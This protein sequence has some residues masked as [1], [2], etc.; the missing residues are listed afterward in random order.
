V[1][2]Q[3]SS[4]L[5]QFQNVPV[6]ESYD[7]QYFSPLFGIEDK[8]YWFRA[9]NQAIVALTRQVVSDL[10]PGYRVLEVGCGTGNVLRVLTHIC[11]R[12]TVIGMDLFGEGLAYARQR[13]DCALIQGDINTPPFAAC[14]DLI[15]LFDVLE[16]LPDDVQV[17][18][19]LGGLLRQGGKLLLTVPAHMSLWSY[20]DVAAH[21]CR[22]YAPGELRETMYR[23]G[24]RVEYLTQYMGSIFPF[25][26]LGR[27]VAALTN[28][29]LMGKA[30]RT[31]DLATN[32]LR[33]I[34]VLNDLLAWLLIQEIR[35]LERRRQLPFGTSLIA[36][37]H[38]E[39]RAA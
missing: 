20:F 16:H 25:V 18:R 5:T 33:I 7:P 6:P 3:E 19:N 23:A 21:H 34:P 31:Y 12:G 38:K 11:Q 37:V 28:R 1:G 2:L 13:V 15:G 27:R 39:P 35:C 32:E 9:R 22:R 30:D 8:H 26:W 29:L 4:S 36:V 17:L 24:Y 14:F 10:A